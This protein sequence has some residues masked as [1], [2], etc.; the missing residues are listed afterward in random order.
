MSS[1]HLNSQVDLLA[2]SPWECYVHP[3]RDTGRMSITTL[4]PLS[5]AQ[6]IDDLTEN[7]RKALDASV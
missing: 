1:V 7:T 6:T 2:K 4:G 3:W 5:D